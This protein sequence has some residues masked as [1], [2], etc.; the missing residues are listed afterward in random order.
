MRSFEQRKPHSLNDIP[1]SIKIRAPSGCY[2]REHSPNA[3]VIIDDY[4]R[5]LPDEAGMVFEE[6][7]SGPELLVWL[8]VTTAGLTLAKSIIDLIAT[9]IK[10]RSEGIRKGDKP[11]RPLE[12]IVRRHDSKGVREEIVL[13]VGHEETVKVSAIEDRIAKG[14][15]N[16]TVSAKDENPQGLGRTV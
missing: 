10:A 6:H 1:I 8:A 5:T 12:L 11:D 14:L 7:E 3:Y 2:H 15:T 16:I 13:R 4:L 9:I